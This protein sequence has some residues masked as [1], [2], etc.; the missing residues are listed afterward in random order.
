MY[1]RCEM[2]SLSQDLK[3]HILKELCQEDHRY[4]LDTLESFIVSCSYHAIIETDHVTFNVIYPRGYAFPKT[5]VMMVCKRLEALLRYN[6]FNKKLE[7]FL[8]PMRAKRMF[9]VSG[10]VSSKNINGAYT[11]RTQRKVYIYRYEEFAKVALHEACHHLDIHVEHWNPKSLIELYREFNVDVAGC[12]NRCSTAILPNEG[13]IEAWAN[14][15]HCAFLSIEYNV[16]LH[17][18]LQ[19]EVEHALI[20]TKKLLSYQREKYPLWQEDTHSF[21]YIVIRTILLYFACDFTNM[22]PPYDSRRMTDFIIEKYNTK[23]F[24]QALENTRVPVGDRHHMRMTRF[25]DF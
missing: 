15:Y 6:N 10:K 1:L 23:E 24:Q 2:S 13:I 9:P 25:G 21:S 16:P 4:T 7:Y 12:P 11:Y 8:I 20:Q 3:N 18:L 5:H 14:I 22:R 17:H 19:A